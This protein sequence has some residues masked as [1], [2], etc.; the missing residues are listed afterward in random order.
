MQDNLDGFALNYSQ[1]WNKEP[2]DGAQWNSV[3]TSVILPIAAKTIWIAEPGDSSREPFQIPTGAF[4]RSLK[5]GSTIGLFA[6]KGAV[7]MRIFA[8]DA[9]AQQPSADGTAPL[10]LSGDDRG[11]PFGAIRLVAYHYEG[12]YVGPGPS[13]GQD[14]HLRFGA[15]MKTAAV[16]PAANAGPK[17]VSELIKSLVGAKLSV[18]TT[19]S[20]ESKLWNVSVTVDGSEPLPTADGSIPAARAE[21]VSLAVARNLTCSE[22]LADNK[23]QSVHTRWNCLVS[24]SIDGAE[25]VTG[26]LTINGQLAPR[27][28]G[29]FPGRER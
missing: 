25:V 13:S 16:G 21:M 9:S 4:N 20:G 18:K 5:V 15:L 22:D 17:V 19:T 26:H 7:A 29:H 8:A 10:F 1:P 27:I 3:S 2:N 14:T 24:R 12:H 28:P 23:N 11:M 6:G